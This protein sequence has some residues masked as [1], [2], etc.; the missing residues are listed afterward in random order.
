MSRKILVVTA[1]RA[2]Y[3][4][5]KPLIQRI[6]GQEEF[7]LVLVVTGTHLSDF[8]GNTFQ[9]IEKDGFIINHKIPLDLSL[10]SQE[11][12]VKALGTV[13][14]ET[15]KV[16][17]YEKP[18]LVIVLGDRYEVLGVAQAA[19]LFNIPLAHLHGGELT[20]GAYDDA[21]RHSIS[22]MSNWH[23]VSAETHRQRVIQL[24][25]DP[26][27]IFNVG[28]LGIENIL[29]QKAEVGRPLFENPYLLI[30]YHPETN[31]AEDRLEELLEALNSFKEFDFIFTGA[32][33]DNRGIRINQRLK[34]YCNVNHN[35]KFIMNLGKDYLNV[36]KYAKAVVGNSSS[37]IIEAAYLE[38]PTVNCGHRQR[39]RLAPDSVYHCEM[40]RTDIEK[41]I[42]AALGHGSS[43][44]YLFGEGNASSMI[45]DVL[46]R[47]NN[48]HVNK[49]FIDL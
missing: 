8:H 35:A 21:I 5:L 39:G 47:I 27:R 10:D 11:S 40:E 30:T 33:A 15:G 13:T 41:A 45:V 7:E 6:Q 28:A 4:L 42:H 18:H 16:L 31:A 38:T 23:F 26:N 43:Y 9:D 44:E 12:T 2:E 46:R 17:E 24:G 36:L 48:F 49:E 32:N 29:K 1:T 20:L 37:G 3:F 19:L 34:E 25:E 22:K 14:S